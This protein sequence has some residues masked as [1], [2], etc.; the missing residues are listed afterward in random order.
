[1]GFQNCHVT[2]L[3]EYIHET[4]EMATRPTRGLLDALGVNTVVICLVATINQ[5]QVSEYNA[6]NPGS[7][8]IGHEI[9]M[10]EHFKPR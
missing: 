4:S 7:A 8:T 10:A 9:S 2:T 6:T 3:F 5:V 1:M